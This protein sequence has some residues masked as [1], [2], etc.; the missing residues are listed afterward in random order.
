MDLI[1]T[2]Y[3]NPFY[4]K[5]DQSAIDCMLTTIS[6]GV[7]PF[8]ADKNDVIYYGK[9]LYDEIISNADSIPIGPYIPKTT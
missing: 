5:E 3:E 4:V 2:K 7:I 9:A 1:W 6:L 8:T